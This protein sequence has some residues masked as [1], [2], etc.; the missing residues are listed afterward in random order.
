MGGEKGKERSEWG[1]EMERRYAHSLEGR[2][3]ESW[4]PLEAHLE[5]V[6]DWAGRLAEP[7]ASTEWGRILGMLHDVGK[8]RE[9]FQRYLASSNGLSDESYDGA[10]HSH[11]GAG[12]IWAGGS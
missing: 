2:P 9:S 7:F 12:A 6:A 5:G 10:D 8:A 4:Q 11:S 1:D 3:P